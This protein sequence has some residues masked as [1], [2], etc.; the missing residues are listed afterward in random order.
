MK[1]TFK[2]MTAVL[3]AAMMAA[4][5]MTPVHA[6]EASLLETKDGKTVDN[7]ELKTTDLS[8]YGDFFAAL[9]ATAEQAK[10]IYLAGTVN[11]K[12]GETTELLLQQPARAKDASASLELLVGKQAAVSVTG[13]ADGKTVKNDNGEYLPLTFKG[14]KEGTD[15]YVAN[16][17]PY[18][19]RAYKFVVGSGEGVTNTDPKLYAETETK[20]T[21]P[22]KEAAEE[23][24]KTINYN[25]A[26]VGVTLANKGS[27]LLSQ[28]GVKVD[29]KQV[30]GV[31]I[32]GHAKYS[33]SAPVA[34]P[35][36]VRVGM[37][38]PED[39]ILVD[40]AA[41]SV[42]KSEPKKAR[43]GMLN[44]EEII[45]IDNAAKTVVKNEPKAV[46]IGMLNAEDIITIDN[47]TTAVAKSEPKKARVGM[48]NEEDIITIDNATT[49]VEKSE[50][51]A[52]RNGFL[53]PEDIIQIL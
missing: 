30:N 50:P 3:A 8:G 51:K 14:E 37:L 10:S 28:G 4:V 42:T 11:L 25:P 36:K 9:G 6:A 29:G 16:I 46:R 34:A 21:E 31:T 41:K 47:A 18:D 43:V 23:P 45:T 32:E 1:K 17:A 38:N 26:P 24:V 15:I 40:N 48:L 52:A 2:R 49:Q 7:A 35:K 22:K 53:N 20:K 13:P 44:E 39:I 19:I 33:P 5:M 12:V 27:N